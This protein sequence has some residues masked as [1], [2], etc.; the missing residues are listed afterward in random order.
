M[1]ESDK[2]IFINFKIHIYATS[3]P[4]FL[5]SFFVNI[6]K[7]NSTLSLHKKWSFQMR[8]PS[9]NV[10]RS[11]GNYEFSH[12]YRRNPYWK[13]SFFVPRVY[14]PKRLQTAK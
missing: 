12:I 6:R 14:G 11:T 13:T 4:L 7:I 8:I 9:V 3:L 5:K 1:D 2:N 10:T